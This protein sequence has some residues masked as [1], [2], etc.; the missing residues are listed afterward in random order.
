MQL[1]IVQCPLPFLGGG[2]S[3]SLS[4][5]SSSS[6]Y[7]TSSSSLP[8]PPALSLNETAVYGC[9][10]EAPSMSCQI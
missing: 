6:S 4:S 7:F 8:P 9:S 3:S 2:L 5:S 1:F 10:P